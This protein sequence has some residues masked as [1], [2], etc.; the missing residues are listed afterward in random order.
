MSFSIN[1]LPYFMSILKV[2]IWILM[3]YLIK[4]KR[5]NKPTISN[6]NEVSA[7]STL[8]KCLSQAHY[9]L[10]IRQ[11]QVKNIVRSCGMFHQNQNSLKNI[12]LI[13]AAYL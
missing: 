11:I 7:P 2:V 10:N 8:G 5:Y 9:W 1:L 4:Y 12:S 6:I 13:M 3:L